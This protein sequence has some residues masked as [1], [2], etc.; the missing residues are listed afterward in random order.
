M[1]AKDIPAPPAKVAERPVELAEYSW[2]AHSVLVICADDGLRAELERLLGRHCGM[3]QCVADCGEAEALLARLHFDLLIRSWANSAHA[4]DE[5]LHE[6]RR[7]GFDGELILIAAAAVDVEQ[8]LQALRAGVA[9]LIARPLRAEVLLDAIRR[10]FE[11]SHLQRGGMALRGARAG[12]APGSV[13]DGLVGRSAELNQVRALIRRIGPTASTV[14]LLGESGTGKEVVAQALHRAST[15]AH[16]A[17]VPLN[18]AAIAPELIESELFG[19][20]KGAFTGAVEQRDGLF[21]AADGGSLFL[22]EISELP[23]AM[24][25]RLLRVLEE[26]RVRP[27]GAEHERAVDVR[28]IAASNRD[29]GAEVAA[30]RFRADLFYRLAV[31]DIELPPLRARRDDIAELVRHFMRE[32]AP[33]LQVEPV[34]LTHEVLVRLHAHSWPGNVRELRNV[35]E[36]ALVLG[37]FAAALGAPP[38]LRAGAATVAAGREASVDGELELTLAEVERRHIERVTAACGGNKSDAAQRL[39]VSRKTLER[40]FADWAAE[41]K[42]DAPI[43]RRA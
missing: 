9:D 4:L 11:R 43:G 17:F 35:V 15:R 28:I 41:A 10:S 12:A 1:G 40:K 3:V 20:R 22:D 33:A 27:L 18:C 21:V 29:L 34:R 26:R 8:A 7:L 39:G 38:S 23:L 30:G 36:R 2:Q 13:G 14:L 42:P 19:H 37:S 32:R 16:A 24:Q 25:A 6:V 5:C 31:V